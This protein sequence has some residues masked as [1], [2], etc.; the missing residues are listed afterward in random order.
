[1]AKESY[2]EDEEESED[3]KVA[4]YGPVN[5]DHFINRND[6]IAMFKRKKDIEMQL[7]MLRDYKDEDMK[8]EFYMAQL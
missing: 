3:K 8:R 1:M 7:D 4:L 5:F 6:K 2:H